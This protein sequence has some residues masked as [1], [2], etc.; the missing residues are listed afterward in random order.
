MITPITL[1]SYMVDFLLKRKRLFISVVVILLVVVGIST[2]CR[3]GIGPPPR[4][5]DL[6]VFMRA[7][8]AIRDGEN[9]YRVVNARGWYYV[10]APLLAILLTPFAAL[11][12]LLNTTF[13]YALSVA[14]LC[15][16]VGLSVRMA[17]D[18]PAGTRAAVMA[19]IFCLP[20]I[21]ESMTRGQVGVMVLFLAVAILYLYLRGKYVWA[22]IL[23]AFSIVLKV[24]PLAFL[25]VFFLAKRE[26]KVC[27]A[28]ALG[29]IFFLFVYPSFAIGAERNWFLLTEWRSSL[30]HAVSGG[31][32]NRL[33]SQ[34][35]TP[36]AWDNQTLYAV[37]TR[38]FYPTESAL[39]A[40]GNAWVKTLVGV[41]AVM[42]LSGLAFVCRRRRSEISERRIMLEYSLFPALM[43]LVS[44]VSEIHHYTVLFMI[45]FAAFLYLEE[46]SQ[47]PLFRQTLAWCC[48]MAALTQILGYIEP[49]AL[50]GFPM[51]G[52]LALWCVSLALVARVK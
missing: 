6:T 37:I 39:E 13:W 40:H 26:W 15:G 51:L 47:R 49:I 50:K 32:E 28:A 36:I 41:I 14:A 24:S 3:G 9:I 44:P 23:L 27:A 10:Y 8:E 20:A 42:A 4:R 12:L 29:G 25:A 18:Q 30:T 17:K 35:A 22:G 19:G 43:L 33:W 31:S 46:L 7:A 2:L 45:F 16:S 52:A 38:W 34:L 5:T 48:F 1:F 21:I 11:P